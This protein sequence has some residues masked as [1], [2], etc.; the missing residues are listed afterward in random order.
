VPIWLPTIKV[1]NHPNLLSYRWHAK[2]H[3]KVVDKGYNIFLDFTSIGSLQKKLWVSKVVGVPILGILGLQTW[4]SWDKMTFGCNP[5]GQT[6]N[7][8][9]RG[10]WLLPPKCGPLW[11]LWVCVCPW[12]IRAPK[13]FQLC[14]NQL[15]VWFVQIH[16]NNWSA[17]HSS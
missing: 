6:Q 14:I 11:V 15:V 17:Y 1:R 5:C 8:L 13:V 4:E 7:I 3:W 10:R 16:M 12:F 9:Q 2:Y